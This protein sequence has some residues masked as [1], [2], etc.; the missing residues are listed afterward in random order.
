M[1][2][3]PNTAQGE[4]TGADDGNAVDTTVAPFNGQ[5]GHAAH[6]GPSG[7]RSFVDTVLGP[8]A[9]RQALFSSPLT[10]VESSR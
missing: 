9:R 4:V 6:L 1:T 7:M 8:K 10:T 2:L 5:N 3:E